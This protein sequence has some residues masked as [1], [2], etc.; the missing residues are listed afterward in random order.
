M[1]VQEIQIKS[2]TSQPRRKVPA[3][4][5]RREDS[6]EELRSL[7]GGRRDSRG[8]E[9]LRRVGCSGSRSSSSSGGGGGG[10]GSSSSSTWITSR[11]ASRV[12]FTGREGGG[13]GEGGGGEGRNET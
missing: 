9:L 11:R 1:Q 12:A 4:T 13:G 5:I 2:S 7:E 3:L 6:P 10:G 8:A